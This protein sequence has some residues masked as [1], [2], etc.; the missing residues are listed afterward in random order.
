MELDA[1]QFVQ[2]DGGEMERVA[3]VVEFGDGGGRNV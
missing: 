2:I 1:N 3:R